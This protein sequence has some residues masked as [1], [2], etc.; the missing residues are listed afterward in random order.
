MTLE[1]SGGKESGG[2][3]WTKSGSGGGLASILNC[4]GKKSTATILKHQKKVGSPKV[5]MV[6]VHSGASV[7]QPSDGWT[8]SGRGW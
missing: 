1:E 4:Q 8:K 2:Q 7:T 3:V 5:L 6:R